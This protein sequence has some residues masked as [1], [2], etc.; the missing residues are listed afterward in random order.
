[1]IMDLKDTYITDLPVVHAILT[2][3]LAKNEMGLAPIGIF[4]GGEWEL[5]TCKGQ[6][7][8]PNDQ[9]PAT[10]AVISFTQNILWKLSTFDFKT[11]TMI[12]GVCMDS[13][14]PVPRATH[15]DL[16]DA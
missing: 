1:M 3:Y 15:H 5:Q 14:Q 6:F 16:F 11:F 13:K 8:D 10:F 2:E 9:E 4:N 7:G 12:G